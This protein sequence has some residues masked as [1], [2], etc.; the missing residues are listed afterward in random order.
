MR[1]TMS[2]DVFSLA[3]TGRDSRCAPAEF[4]V[5]VLLL[6]LL[7]LLPSVRR[8]CNCDGDWEVVILVAP[9]AAFVF[10]VAGL[11]ALELESVAAIVTGAFA[12]GVEAVAVGV[13]ELCDVLCGREEEEEEVCRV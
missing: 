10:A 6:L 12:A 7:L 3:W 9:A 11:R 13:L 1:R 2:A 5:L 8:G 4:V